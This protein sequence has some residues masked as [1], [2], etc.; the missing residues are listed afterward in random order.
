MLV[1]VMFTRAGRRERRPD[2]RRVGV[3]MI[4][5]GGQQGLAAGAALVT[6][7]GGELCARRLVQRPAEGGKPAEP[8]EPAQTEDRSHSYA[9][10]GTRSAGTATIT[11]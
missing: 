6:A 4:S 2:P 7:G 10:A 8:D 9:A 11:A 3:G 5:S 1:L